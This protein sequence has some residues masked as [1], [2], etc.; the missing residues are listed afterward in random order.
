M[1]GQ[2][3]FQQAIRRH[4]GRPFLVA[5]VLVS[6]TRSRALFLLIVPPLEAQT[7]E[8]HHNFQP[9]RSDR[10]TVLA[11]VSLIEVKLMQTTELFTQTK[12]YSD[13]FTFCLLIL[14]PTCD[15]TV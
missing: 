10:V 13:R 6:E 15:V 9:G 7:R 11:M 5:V 12:E 8:I 1:L 3:T 4:Y 2:T 14:R